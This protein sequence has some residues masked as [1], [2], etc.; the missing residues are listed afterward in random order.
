[1]YKERAVSQINPVISTLLWLAGV[2]LFYIL[3]GICE[4]IFEFE[5]SA[6]K[7]AAILLVTI[8]YGFFLI[9]KVLT[10]YEYEYCDGAF[11]VKSILS[12]REKQ[13][14]YA[15]IGTNPKIYYDKKLVDKKEIKYEKRVSRPFQKGVTGYIVFD[16]D[17]GKTLIRLKAT[18]E[19]FDIMQ[20]G[21][22]EG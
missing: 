8:W 10:Q 1:M 3:W 19:F 4:I 14:L 17:K 11:I 15:R 18:P 7:N 6:G 13:L 9:T 20:K 12:K 22:A 2:Y 5:F 16:T 21:R